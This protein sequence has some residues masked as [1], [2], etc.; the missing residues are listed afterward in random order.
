VILVG[1]IALIPELEIPHWADRHNYY[2]HSNR[3]PDDGVATTDLAKVFFDKCYVRPL[4]S[5]AWNIVNN[6]GHT[7]GQ[8]ADAWETIKKLDQKHNYSDN[9]VMLGGRLAQ[10]AVDAV[11]IEN[12]PLNLAIEESLK[13]AESYK[14]RNWDDGS[15]AKNLSLVKDDLEGVIKNSI[16]GIKEALFGKNQI[17]GEIE[18]MGRL[19]G[20]LLPYNTR[21]DY[22]KCGDLK[23]KWTK[24]KKQHILKNGKMSVDRTPP[25]LPKD[26]SSGWNLRNVYQ[27]AGFYALNGKKPPFLLYASKSDYRLFTPENCEQLQPDF[28]ESIILR[29]SQRNQSTEACLRM[30]QN[31]KELL[32]L[33]YPTFSNFFWKSAP[34]AYIEEAEKVWGDALN[35]AC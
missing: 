11:L 15:D 34:P 30:A 12:R 18:L 13:A 35:H 4:V 24:T 3:G 9:A 26:L 21:P 14:V 29:I 17:I 33:Q 7:D 31:Q 2:W 32:G 6:E 1:R 27:A 23:T 5:S 16:E 25:S 19:N 22:D 20:N 8:K 10:T 28:L